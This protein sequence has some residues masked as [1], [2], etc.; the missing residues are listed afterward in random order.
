MIPEF[1]LNAKM[2]KNHEFTSITQYVFQIV[3]R[4]IIIG[5]VTR[6]C[7]NNPK[8]QKLSA[9]FFTTN[10]LIYLKI[11]HWLISL[12]INWV[13]FSDIGQSRLTKVDKSTCKFSWINYGMDKT[14]QNYLYSSRDILQWSCCAP[15][16]TTQPHLIGSI[17]TMQVTIT[18]HVTW[19]ALSIGTGKPV[20][21][22][23]AL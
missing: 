1:L 2:K 16:L 6:I 5:A 7:F 3:T 20:G 11:T 18:Q 13:C 23:R 8:S 22:I 4:N 14:K 15:V 9:I 10:L 19:E 12:A 21:F 17:F